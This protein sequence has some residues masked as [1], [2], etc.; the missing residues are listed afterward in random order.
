MPARERHKVFQRNAGHDSG[1]NS[2][3]VFYPRSNR[4]R[5]GEHVKVMNLGRCGGGAPNGFEACRK[6][7]APHFPQR[8]RPPGLMDTEAYTRAIVGR[9]GRWLGCVVQRGGSSNQR[10]HQAADVDCQPWPFERWCQ[11]RTRAREPEVGFNN[12]VRLAQT[13][14]PCTATMKQTEQAVQRENGHGPRA[15]AGGHHQRDGLV[16]RPAPE[17]VFKGL[18]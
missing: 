12:C 5:K 10:T 2:T 3:L 18:A 17:L 1:V 8:Q 15:V 16:R 9:L 7:F 14:L 4:C 6:M 11:L 13:A